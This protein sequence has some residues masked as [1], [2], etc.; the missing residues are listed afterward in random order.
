MRNPAKVWEQLAQRDEEGEQYLAGRKLLGA[1]KLDLVRFRT[2]VVS[3][4]RRAF[5]GEHLELR[6]RGVAASACAH[7]AVED[8]AR[9]ARGPDRQRAALRAEPVAVTLRPEVHGRGAS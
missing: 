4:V 7:V 6:R 1:V 9:A 2:E 5:D 8:V 3:G